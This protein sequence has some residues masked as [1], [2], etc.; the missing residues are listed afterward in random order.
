MALA[1]IVH[2][3]FVLGLVGVTLYYGTFVAFR[4]GDV[5]ARYQANKAAKDAQ[6][7]TDTDTAVLDAAAQHQQGASSSSNSNNQ[8]RSDTEGHNEGSDG[9][10]AMIN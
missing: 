8:P 5:I 4:S 10:S 6:N 2:K 9:S 3:G 7:S 1:D